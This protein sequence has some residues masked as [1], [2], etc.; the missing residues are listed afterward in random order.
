M[1][2]PLTAPELAPG[3]AHLWEFN[4]DTQLVEPVL[5]NDEQTRAD[6][7]HFDR[8]HRRYTVGRS[9]LRRLLAG[10]LKVKPSEIAFTYGT[11]GKPLLP[12]SKLSFNLAHSGPHAILAV[13]RAIP[14]GVDIE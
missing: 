10:Y 9:M 1:N 2:D 7:F 8:D 4:L 5:S 14:I 6:K 13:T 3:M 12:D 11:A